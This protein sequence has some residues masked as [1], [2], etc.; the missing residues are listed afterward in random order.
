MPSAPP[1]E[2]QKAFAEEAA[3]RRRQQQLGELLEKL[4]AVTDTVTAHR[5]EDEYW[6]EF[7]DGGRY[8]SHYSDDPVILLQEAVGE[9]QEKRCAGPCG[10]KKPVR[11]F[12]RDKSRPD[13]RCP[14]CKTCERERVAAYSR[15]RRAKPSAN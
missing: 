2:V 11:D 14:R 3:R 15:K 4:F 13:G 6:L 8:R 7:H 5:N 1:D 12:A 10:R 9:A